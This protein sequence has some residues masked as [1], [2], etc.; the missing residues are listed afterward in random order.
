MREPTRN[1]ERNPPV[2]LDYNATTPLDPAVLEAMWPYAERYF[3][4]PS[5]THW[6]GQQAARAIALARNQVAELLNCQA[7]EVIFTSGGTE[8]NNF[9]L[10]GVAFA[11]KERGNHILTTAIEH[12]AVTEVCRFLERNGFDVAFLPVDETGR[13]E[14]ATLESAIT[15][16]TILV[17]VMHANN[18]VGTIQPIEQIARITREREIIFH[19]DA[20]QT[21]GKIPSDVSLLGVDLLSVAGHKLY[22]PKGVG[23]LYIRRGLTL[24]KLL[25]GAGHEQG[26][27][28]GTENVLG[29]VG[30]G[31]ACARATS[32]LM[33]NRRHLERMRNQLFEGLS[34]AFPALQ[35][36]G[37]PDLRLP[38]TL[39]ISIPGVEAHRLLEDVQHQVA[40]SAG[41][42]CHAGRMEGS[43]V[44]QAMRISDERAKGAIRLSTGQMTTEQE[45]DK[46]LQAIIRVARDQLET[47]GKTEAEDRAEFS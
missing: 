5:S 39:N 17:S 1:A 21:V 10:Q 38:N 7:E 18:E 3:G 11:M 33:Q 43:S 22:A 37:H 20:A 36:N 13:L 12:P 24:E 6:Y 30:L 35:L 9:A 4:N 19:T 40:A 41:A 32:G 45:I 15:P 28:P 34:L 29:I 23:A 16:R 14:L 2:Y 46:A 8:A 31:A 44:L 42:A 47:S 27:R 26:R 25:Y